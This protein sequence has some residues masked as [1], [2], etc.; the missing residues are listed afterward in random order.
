MFVFTIYFNL[1]KPGSNVQMIFPINLIGRDSG[2]SQIRWMMNTILVF[3]TGC[4]GKWWIWTKSEFE[5]NEFYLVA[6]SL[7]TGHA[8]RKVSGWE[9]PIDLMPGPW[10]FNIS[11]VTYIYLMLYLSKP[12]FLLFF[13]T[14]CT[15][16]D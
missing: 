6:S 3:D 12:H 4:W 7:T 10:C 15:K 5:P 16:A 11:F 2:R 14:H 9:P 13:E 1:D 8:I